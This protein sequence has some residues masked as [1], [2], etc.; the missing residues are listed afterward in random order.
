MAKTGLGQQYNHRGGAGILAC[1]VVMEIQSQHL[2]QIAQP[3]PAVAF[4]V[5]PGAPGDLDAVGPTEIRGI[6]AA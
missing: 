3:M 4:E 2:L 1:V 6:K 5:R